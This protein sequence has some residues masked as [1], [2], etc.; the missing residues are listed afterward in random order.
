[1]PSGRLTRLARDLLARLVHYGYS[2]IDTIVCM[3][4]A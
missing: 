2:A 1:M 4:D 3:A